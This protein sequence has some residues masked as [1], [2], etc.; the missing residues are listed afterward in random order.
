VNTKGTRL[1]FGSFATRSQRMSLPA[2]G[3]VERVAIYESIRRG[4]QNVKPRMV[5]IKRAPIAQ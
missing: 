5:P 2:T 1:I 3:P 4:S